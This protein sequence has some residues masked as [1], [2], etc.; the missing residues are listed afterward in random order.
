MVLPSAQALQLQSRIW[1]PARIASRKAAFRALERKD[2]ILRLATHAACKMDGCSCAGWKSLNA[3]RNFLFPSNNTGA[4]PENQLENPN[5]PCR[6]CNHS[7]EKHISDLV[8]LTDVAIDEL[9]GT[10]VDIETIFLVLQ[11]DPLMDDPETKQIFHYL[12]RLLRK[13]VA[14][15][16]SPLPDFATLGRPPYEEPSISRALMA[17]IAFR[18]CHVN[19]FEWVAIVDLGKILLHTINNCKMDSPSVAALR[20]GST[21][22]DVYKHM[23]TRWLILCQAPT[24]CDS[25]PKYDV[26]TIF[27]RQLMKEIF[28]NV[29]K[30]IL[31]KF[32]MEQE[33]I[34]P[35]KRELYARLLPGFLDAVEEAIHT[36]NCP[37]WDVNFRP[38]LPPHAQPRA[39]QQQ[40]NNQSVA[41]Q[42]PNLAAVVAST[43]AGK[44]ATPTSTVTVFKKDPGESA[45]AELMEVDQP[46]E[47]PSAAAASMPVA[48]RTVKEEHILKVDSGLATTL[49]G[50]PMV[51]TTSEVRN[52]TKDLI[53]EICRDLDDSQVGGEKDS[54]FDDSA[55]RDEAA[56]KEESKRIIS[57]HVI[58]NSLSAGV[59]KETMMWL[60][61]LQNVFSHQL[62]RMPKEY[63]TRLVFDTKHKNLALI[64]DG[65]PIG[66]ICFRMFPTQGF[67]E[68]VFCAVTSN[69][70]VKGYGTHLMNQLKDYHIK[71]G[72][73]H[74]LTYA[75]EFAIGY[76]K[77]QGFSMEITVSRSMYSGF[78]KEYE[79]ATLMHCELNPC[80]RYTEFTTVV[81]RQKQ[82]M[83]K[84]VKRK[85]EDLHSLIMPGVVRKDGQRLKEI[86]GLDQAAA[87]CG[88]E[89]PYIN[90][91]DEP[92]ITTVF[93]SILNQ[94]KNHHASWPFVKPVDKNEVPD[95][96]DYIQFPMDLKTMAD[97][98]KK[99][100]YIHKR[101]FAADM[102]RIFTNCRTYNSQETEYYR[103]A[104]LLEK[105][106]NNKLRESGLSDK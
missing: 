84:I 85:Y 50:E 65:R 74:F 81:R 69:E 62:P 53:L 16:C 77:K 11:R 95:Y 70:Q 27:G 86:P 42:A 90:K 49:A 64:K 88:V 80:I 101:L 20:V 1:H 48:A 5:E 98:L 79:G 61:G 12:F 99:G 38:L 4:P 102:T 54:L 15:C 46:Q 7:L 29:K 73:L 47:H 91:E 24:L 96:Y 2:K 45:E 82:I 55:A 14:T 33:K 52:V 67:A 59:S 97:R 35:T 78:I 71:H 13:S 103:C 25:L 58:A 106:F 56:R 105:F 30:Q 44:A 43:V 89:T 87:I 36:P 76:F 26:A 8:K 17:L 37:V 22:Y 92:N 9:I 68:I 6:N 39:Q 28:P 94:V 83:M 41:Q 93:K 66:G 21:G 10:M 40:Q 57:C 63:I 72:V 32:R 31:E 19:S 18:Y 104:N 23:Y 34:Q 75:D 51:I 60:I 100:Y 3:G